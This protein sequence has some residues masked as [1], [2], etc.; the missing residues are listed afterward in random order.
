[1]LKIY[2]ADISLVL[3]KRLQLECL[4]Q[5]YSGLTNFYRCALTARNFPDH[6]ATATT[7]AVGYLADPLNAQ[8]F[9]LRWWFEGYVQPW[10]MDKY[11]AL[12]LPFYK[13]T[14][15]WYNRFKQ[16]GLEKTELCVLMFFSVYRAGGLN[17]SLRP[18]SGLHV[19]IEP[20]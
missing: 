8:D 2:Q 20:W 15:R 5:A 17:E 4:R 12:M 9:D 7:I 1:M 19:N 18:K 11:L 14:I 3:T 6:T 10:A 16:L 13:A